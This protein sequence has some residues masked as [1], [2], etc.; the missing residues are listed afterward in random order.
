[1]TLTTRTLVLKQ[2]SSVL[3]ETPAIIDM[4]RLAG[5]TVQNES[6]KPDDAATFIAGDIEIYVP[7]KGLVD[8]EAEL[9]KLSKERE[10]VEIKLRQINGK[11]GNAGFLANAPADVVDKEKEKKDT[12]D[13]RLAKITEAE[14][15]LKKVEV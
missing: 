15:K 11:L 8:V 9:A 10:K 2:L 14:E 4:T 7:L 6:T 5:L 13:A 3:H 12:L 1:M